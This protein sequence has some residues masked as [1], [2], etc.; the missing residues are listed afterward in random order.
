MRI[1]KTRYLCIKKKIYAVNRVI[2]SSGSEDYGNKITSKT[3]GSKITYPKLI[4]VD[5]LGNKNGGYVY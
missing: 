4:N 1:I 3:S 5:N 2:I